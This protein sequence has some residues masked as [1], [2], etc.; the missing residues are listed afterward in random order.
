MDQGFTGGKRRRIVVGGAAQTPVAGPGDPRRPGGEADTRSRLM[1]KLRKAFAV[2]LMVSSPSL[3]LGVASEEERIDA[4]SEFLLERAKANLLYVFER[5]I[6]QDRAVRCYFP[7]I[8]T[9]VSDG[10]MR[11]LLKGR[12]IWSDS[13]KSDLAHLVVRAAA[14]AVGKA[15]DFS[16]LAL[17][18]TD[19]Y[20]ELFSYMS[21]KYEGFEYPL[22]ASSREHPQELRAL[23][24]GFWEIN[25]LR[26][27]M[28]VADN[29]LK[30]TDPVCDLPKL[31]LNDVRKFV[32]DLKNAV[33]KLEAWKRHIETNRG[34][35][36]LNAGKLESYCRERPARWFCIDRSRMAD[37]GISS[38]AAPISA[39]A[40]STLK[41]AGDLESFLKRIDE[42]QGNTAKVLIVINF[43]KEN[44]FD[45]ELIESF[46]RYVLFFAEL[47]DAD[48]G[49]QVKQ[50]LD[51][52]TMPAV[53]FAVKR[54]KYKSHV[55][56]S[57]YLGIFYGDVLNSKSV[58]NGNRNG[59]FAPVGVEYSYGRRSGNSLSVLFAPFD[60][61]YP[62]SL[63]LNGVTSNAK[64]SDVIAPSV[65]VARGFANYPLAVGAV[66]QR[67]RKDE[68]TGAVEQ[69]VMLFFGF[70]MPLL[71][72]Y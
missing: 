36:V 30:N 65:M 6:A 68:T 54:E 70:D 5:R 29:A 20:I 52:Y 49:A 18:A 60:L 11:L 33:G 32:S 59:I 16:K 12:A 34:R 71:P 25:D 53:S 15:A 45:D 38:V 17:S 3:C 56:V 58:G 24:N 4:V 21:V 41:A 64:L 40:A 31:E 9:Y 35:I 2:F 28:L 46:K 37:F 26:D 1:S 63:K 44:A 43:F 7:T 27:L 55:F 67:G 39:R 13:I 62:I 10:D 66:Y 69:R 42:A 14:K 8:Y 19:D 50:I 47:S 22:S 48:S 23:I 61:G 51:E 57:S 72:L